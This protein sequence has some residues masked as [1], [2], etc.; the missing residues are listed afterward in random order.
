MTRHIF[1]FEQY[2]VVARTVAFL[3]ELHVALDGVHTLVTE[4]KEAAGTLAS[5]L[6]ETCRA[7]SYELSETLKHTIPESKLHGYRKTVA[8]DVAVS[9]KNKEGE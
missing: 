6:A 8:I 4:H 1:T 5:L 7:H 2:E 9:P 3:D